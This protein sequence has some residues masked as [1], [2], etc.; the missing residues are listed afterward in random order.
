M[1]TWETD[2]VLMVR[3]LINDLNA[4]QKNTDDYIEQI[5]VTGGVLVQTEVDLAV[6][7]NFDVGAST[8]SP[9]PI[10]NSDVVTQGLLALKAA[11][12]SNQGSF[13]TAVG[14]GIKVRDGDTAIDTSVSFRGFRDILEVGPCGAYERLKTDVQRANSQNL[15]KAVMTAFREG[16]VQGIGT[17]SWYFDSLSVGLR[18]ATTGDTREFR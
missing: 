1:A 10:D 13:I 8:I 14:Q 5:I 18:R 12:I 16:G 15:G 17:V 4:P 7:Y 2:L 11:C 6:S 9:D 3:V